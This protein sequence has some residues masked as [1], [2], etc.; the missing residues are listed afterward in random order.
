MSLVLTRPSFVTAR[1]SHPTNP[2]FATPSQV[3][4]SNFA[5]SN[6][7]I[8]AMLASVTLMRQ[9]ER[10]EAGS[11]LLLGSGSGRKA[12]SISA[13]RTRVSGR[14]TPRPVVRSARHV[15]QSACGR[16]Q[17]LHL[18][19]R[20]IDPRWILASGLIPATAAPEL[21]GEVDCR[22]PCANSR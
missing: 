15:F 4:T 2:S 14:G 3:L 1:R 12:D 17:S 7:P 13:G 11:R 5:A 8:A 9:N 6:R 19:P 10:D 22:Q 16:R 18:A 20:D 21:I